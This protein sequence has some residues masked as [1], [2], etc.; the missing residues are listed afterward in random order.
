MN[1]LYTLFSLIRGRR[2]QRFFNMFGNSRT[3][4]GGIILWLLLG[5]TTLGVIGRRITRWVQKI[6]EG[7]NN[8]RNNTRIP[9][10]NQVNFANEFAEEVTPKILNK[11]N[12]Q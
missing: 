12:N 10:K 8:L 11:N 5:L 9:V 1:N 2:D 3:N 6:Q 4:N 7:Y